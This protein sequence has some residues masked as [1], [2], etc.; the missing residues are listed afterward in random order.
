MVSPLNFSLFAFSGDSSSRIKGSN[1][2]RPIPSRQESSVSGYSADREEPSVSPPVVSIDLL[3]VGRKNVPRDTN[4][5]RK[6][7][8]RNLLE[9]SASSV[10]ADLV[11]AGIVL[12]KMDKDIETTTCLGDVSID[13]KGVRLMHSSEFEPPLVTSNVSAQSSVFDYAQLTKACW[14]YYPNVLSQLKH[15]KGLASAQDSVRST[16]SVSDTES[17][18]G[19]SNGNAVNHA[20][21]FVPPRLDDSHAPDKQARPT[22]TISGS[23]NIISCATN[24]VT[25]SEVLQLSK[26]AR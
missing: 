5:C 23:C 20:V 22:S 15:S 18:S 16:S 14:D 12:P 24:A 21:L 6:R 10:K 7:R 4:A 8:K 2:K 11:R 3:G 19:A 9:F 1:R 26:I 17:D 13:L 25:M